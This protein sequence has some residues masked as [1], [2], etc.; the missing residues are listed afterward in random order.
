MQSLITGKMVF[1]GTEVQR[2]KY[3]ENPGRVMTRERLIQLLHVWPRYCNFEYLSINNINLIPSSLLQRAVT[4]AI[5]TEVTDWSETERFGLGI[6]SDRLLSWL[7][8]WPHWYKGTQWIL[9]NRNM[10][11]TIIKWCKNL[12]SVVGVIHGLKHIY[13][14]S[15]S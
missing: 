3:K 4:E 10:K 15:L 11:I 1:F 8:L 2:V 13:Y 14:S 9:C 6:R 5:M 12:R 7:Y